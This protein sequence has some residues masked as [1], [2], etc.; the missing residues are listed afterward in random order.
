MRGPAAS[1]G[2]GA[3]SRH[4]SL[5]NGR[6]LLRVR[7]PLRLSVRAPN[8][9]GCAVGGRLHPLAAFLARPHLSR[10][11]PVGQP[12][13]PLPPC[14]APM[15]CGTWHAGP[16][17]TASRSAFRR[18]SRATGC[19][20]PGRRW[21]PCGKGGV[22]PSARRFTGPSFRRMPTSLHRTWW[23]RWW[24][25]CHQDTSRVLALAQTPEVKCAA[26]RNRRRTGGGYFRGTE[27][28]GGGRAVLGR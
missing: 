12:A 11:G 25:A 8:S 21:W 15:P 1:R 23:G 26:G 7:Q 6:L 27:L 10:G 17:A 19:S 18:P 14:G 4:D 20:P 5:A 13:Q 2:E 16:A 3:A 24:P 28:P 22:R 9:G